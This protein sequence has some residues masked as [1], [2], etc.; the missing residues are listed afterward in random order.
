MVGCLVLPYLCTEVPRPEG[1]DVAKSAKPTAMAAVGLASGPPQADLATEVRR[2]P[3]L[4]GRAVAVYRRGRVSELSPEAEQ[5]GLR[6]GM[7]LGHAHLICPRAEF[8]PYDQDLYA[9]AQESA[10][11][12]CATYLSVIEP[13]SLQEIFFGLSDAAHAL[14]MLA[15]IEKE[16]SSQLGFT[17]LAG[18]GISKLVA[19]IVAREQPGTEVRAGEEAAF[20]APLPV[21]HLWPLREEV[22]QHLEDLGLHTIGLLQKVSVSFLTSRF[23]PLG[24][25]LHE[26]AFGLDHSPVRPLYPPPV[27]EVRLSLPGGVKDATALG[28]VLRQ[29]AAQVAAQL[30]ARGQT[31][32]QVA[33]RIEMEDGKSTSRR[34]RSGFPIGGE[35]GVFLAA[36]RLL[37][38]ARVKTAISVLTL[39]VTRLERAA[40]RQADLWG[41]R[42]GRRPVQDPEGP[43]GYAQGRPS[44]SEGRARERLSKALSSVQDRFGAQGMK[45]AGEV[46]VPRR[47]RALALWTEG[48]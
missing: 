48:K 38:R 9:A 33:L 29:L 13:C 8:L 27:I 16:V 4:A 5:A 43:F 11:A 32:R 31:C 14:P 37:D 41:E 20:L 36:Q 46:E 17:C 12:I 21:S 1:R 15:E 39:Q 24:K 3:R 23:G 34:L 22:V 7:S 18:A 28:L 47:E 35:D 44:G 40:G 45:W 25:T 2:N 19:R 30:Q 42:E 6:L 10:L 26:L